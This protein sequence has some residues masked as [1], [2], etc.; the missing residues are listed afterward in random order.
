MLGRKHG[1]T[2]VEIL[3]V[4][5]MLAILAAMIMPR[6]VDAQD[7]ARESA[8]ETDIQMVRRQIL[9]YRA[10]HI[11]VGP[12][13]DASGSLDANNI[14]ARLIG[15]T[16][17]DGTINAGGVCG[18]YMKDWPTNPFSSSAGDAISFGTDATAPRNGSTGWYYNT[19]T[20]ELSANSTEGGEE[21]DPNP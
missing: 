8:I 12:H 21:L 7:D 2:L 16:D 11:G 17:P 19:N 6:I 14:P 9:V 20:C 13:L 5:T 15:R 4:I 1:F 10:Q 18:P 3:I